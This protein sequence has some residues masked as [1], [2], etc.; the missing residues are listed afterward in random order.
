MLDVVDLGLLSVVLGDGLSSPVFG[1]NYAVIKSILFNLAALDI[2][3]KKHCPAQGNEFNFDVETSCLRLTYL[4]M[5]NPGW[6]RYQTFSE[7]INIFFPD[8]VI[9][10]M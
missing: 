1:K 6:K 2:S 9:G 4:L 5:S 10:I 3:Q 7:I 8:K